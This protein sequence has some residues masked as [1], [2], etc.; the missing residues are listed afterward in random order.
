MSFQLLSRFSFCRWLQYQTLTTDFLSRSLSAISATRWLDGRDST[1]NCASRE[2]RSGPEIV[3][4]RRLLPAVAGHHAWPGGSSSPCSSVARR[5][6]AAVSHASSAGRSDCMLPQLS[7]IVSKRQTVLWL[8]AV[9]VPRRLTMAAPTSA[10][11]APSR[12]RRSRNC[13][14]K[15]RSSSLVLFELAV[16]STLTVTSRYSLSTSAAS[17]PPATHPPWI[18]LSWRRKIVHILPSRVYEACAVHRSCNN[19]ELTSYASDVP[20]LNGEPVT[21]M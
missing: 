14:A 21:M 5:F 13:S 9:D 4:R 12:M 10:W 1:A 19:N 2:R 7:V 17:P 15:R 6:S 3:V 18:V 16:V 20:N 11:V 8:S